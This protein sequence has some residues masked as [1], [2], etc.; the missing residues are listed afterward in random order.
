MQANYTI[1]KSHNHL[2]WFV[3][4]QV[5]W[6]PLPG[7]DV[8]PR[9]PDFTQRNQTSKKGEAFLKKLIKDN[10]GS[11]DAVQLSLDSFEDMQEGGQV[12][13]LS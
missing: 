13:Y 5:L 1:E 10:M 4:K 9:L 8:D 7:I 11:S 2:A 6:Q 12:P 3:T